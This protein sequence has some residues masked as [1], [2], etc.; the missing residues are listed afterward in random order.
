MPGPGAG[1]DVRRFTCPACGARVGAPCTEPV[2]RTG[3]PRTVPP[4]LERRRKALAAKGRDGVVAV[5]SSQFEQG[6][7]R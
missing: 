6:K 2:R 1:R 3:R 4:H 5:W 7:G